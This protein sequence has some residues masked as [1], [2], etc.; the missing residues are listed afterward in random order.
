[1]TTSKDD[2][3]TFLNQYLEDNA[4]K[5]VKQLTTRIRR[6]YEQAQKE[7]NKKAREYLADFKE[8]DKEMKQQVKDG[9]LTKQEYKSWKEYKVLGTKRW[10]AVKQDIAKQINGANEIA[11]NMVNEERK[12][13]FS[14]SANNVAFGMSKDFNAL[15]AFT[16]YDNATVTRLLK[17]QPK[18]LPDFT[19]DNGKA[20]AWTYKHISSAVT[21]SIIQGESLY[22]LADRI[23]DKV[24]I[25]SETA[26]KRVART[27][28]TSAQN[29]GR[30]EAMKDAEEYGIEVQKEWLATLDSFTRDAHAYMD[31]QVRN[32]DEPFDSALGEIDY[33]GDPFAKPANVWN[34]R[35]TMIPHYPK[36][37]TRME[38]RVNERDENGNKP[39][40]SSLT[41]TQ[42]Q[43]AKVAD[44]VQELSDKKSA[45]DKAVQMY[46][47]KSGDKV[48]SGIWKD[49]VT[50]ADYPDKKD[51]IQAK[52][53]YYH[54]KM[55]YFDHKYA[56][57]D[58][59]SYWNK[60]LE[61]EAKLM[62]LKE[63]E[64][65]GKALYEAL[66]NSKNDF[67]STLKD[68]LKNNPSSQISTV[69]IGGQFAQNAWDEST[70][71]AALNFD[72]KKKADDYHRQ[73][74]DSMWDNLKDEEK[75]SVWE[76]TH[77]SNPIN[78]PLSGYHDDWS[79]SSF[80]GALNTDWGHEDQ[81]RRVTEYDMLKFA[82]DSSGH[83]GYKNVITNLTNAI[84]KSTFQDGVY[85]VRGSDENGFAGMIEGNT[86]SF[87]D[88]K[89]ILNYGSLQEKKD[90]FI[91]LEIRNDAF[92]STGIASGTGFSGEVMYEI[93]AP[94]GT[95]A[96]YAEPQS[97]YGDTA[98]RHIYKVGEEYYGV[99]GEAEVILQRGTTFRITDIESK[100]YGSIKVRM[101][102]V[103]QPDY[104]KYGDENTADMGATRHAT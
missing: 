34:C 20:T 65:N 45:Y 12:A 75:Y 43:S 39:V 71:Q 3:S 37:A 96:I 64:A 14:M 9:L 84:Q 79:R 62:E 11:Y 90:A 48:Y 31:G 2:W 82:K 61:M 49:D 42:W 89:Q 104:F 59:E 55:T 78:K 15:A 50:L 76:Y 16:L 81:W 87:S 94:K 5:E 23:A 17:E 32:L 1:M 85:L 41:Y 97:Y 47:F 80:I 57:T 72:S 28:M 54:Q 18:L 103:E 99:G 66:E 91:G 95:H 24:S 38:R 51:S 88:A 29:A 4:D 19:P 69:K 74:L 33:P 98:S 44:R 8:Q 67:E 10:D 40:I 101:E 25:S 60:Y 92:T 36:N 93:Y 7:I 68:I 86:F 13:L 53:D 35:C 100:G 70:K 77:N 22:A 73:Q 6:T 83:V 46:Q 63:F 58:D 21:Q 102:I 26:M 56:Q 27:A 52:E 30:L